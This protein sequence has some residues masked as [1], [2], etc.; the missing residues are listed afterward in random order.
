MDIASA[1]TGTTSLLR[2]PDG[3]RAVP[4]GMRQKGKRGLAL[5]V[6]YDFHKLLVS[7]Y[8]DTIKIRVNAPP[9]GFP[10]DTQSSLRKVLGVSVGI[11]PA[12]DHITNS[13]LIIQ[14]VTPAVQL[15]IPSTLRKLGCRTENVQLTELHI[16]LD[17][18]LSQRSEEHTSEL[19]SLMRIS[20]AVLCL[21]K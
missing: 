15:K 6:E 4:T 2:L 11:T 18:Y 14:D 20:Y 10:T 1:E 9:A 13:I 16:A 8:L 3:I 5:Q 7:A 19:Q 17:V 21:K 12:T